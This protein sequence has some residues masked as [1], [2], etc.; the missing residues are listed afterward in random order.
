MPM[1]RQAVYALA[2]PV[3]DPET[4]IGA[5]HFW[6]PERLISSGLTVNI[7]ME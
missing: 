5:G 6:A 1:H 3:F 2:N 4:Q 7:G